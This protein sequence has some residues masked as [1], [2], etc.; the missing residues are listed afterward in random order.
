MKLLAPILLTVALVVATASA[1]CGDGQETSST[2]QQT[3]TS[4]DPEVQRLDGMARRF[5]PVDLTADISVLPASERQALAKIVEAARVF[6]ALFLRQVWEG[7]ETML[8]DL[9]QDSSPLGRARLHYFL[10]NKGPW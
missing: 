9:V 4:T 8:L 1:G 6:D 7:N 10:L 3:Q 5:A 2:V